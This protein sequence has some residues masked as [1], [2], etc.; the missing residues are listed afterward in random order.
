MITHI[1]KLEDGAPVGFPVLTEQLRSPM[2]K[3]NSL[4]QIAE[5]GYAPLNFLQYSPS[6]TPWIEKSPEAT[7]TLE[8]DGWVS[9]EYPETQNDDADIDLC[10]AHLKH[11]TANKRYDVE[12]D[13][14]EVDG[15]E[16]STDRSS[17]NAITKTKAAFDNGS[18][19]T[20]EWKN[21]DG[22]FTTH[23]ST[24]FTALADAVAAFVA[25]CY[26][27]EK[28][29]REEIEALTTINEIAA[30]DTDRVKEIIESL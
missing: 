22:S 19:T 23:D 15:V 10:K 11:W 3:L 7:F 24:S 28:Q 5:A 30:F 6:G 2:L 17:Q 13:G 8:E 20:I 16:V 14:V 12:T 21:E 25:K 26:T 29:A 9:M 1:I 18:I 4:D 27:A